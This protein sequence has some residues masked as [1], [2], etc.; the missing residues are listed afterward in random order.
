MQTWRIYHG[1]S[2]PIIA[3]GKA[4]CDLL[5]FLHQYQCWHTLAKDKATQRALS[6][7][8]KQGCIESN[9]CDQYR[10]VYPKGD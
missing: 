5:G 8:I 4:Q 9:D 3:R 1:R 6:A 10:F 7:L 2:N